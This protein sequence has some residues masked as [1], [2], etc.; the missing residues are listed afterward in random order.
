MF[1]KISI[2]VSNKKVYIELNAHDAF[3]ESQ[4]GSTLK[5]IAWKVK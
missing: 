4:S 5:L 1:Y 2:A 3:P